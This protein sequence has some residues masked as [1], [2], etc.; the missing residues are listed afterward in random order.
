MTNPTDVVSVRE[1]YSLLDDKFKELSSELKERDRENWARIM[2][3]KSE[4]DATNNLFTIRHDKEIEA[5]NKEIYGKGE[6]RGLRVR[7]T[8][9]ERNT[10]IA[11]GLQA[12]LTTVAALIAGW[13]G[14]K[15]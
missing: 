1:L 11:H 12:T 14:T 8:D 4:T 13:W 2:Q 7:M 10:G 5:L 9:L 6:D 15:N 3:M